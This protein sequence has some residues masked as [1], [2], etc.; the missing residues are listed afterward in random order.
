MRLSDL[1]LREDSSGSAVGGTAIGTHVGTLGAWADTVK[2]NNKKRK[3]KSGHTVM[4]REAK[5]SMDDLWTRGYHEGQ[6]IG[7][8]MGLKDRSTK[9][10]PKFTGFHDPLARGRLTRANIYRK[11]Y[12]AGL[13]DG[14]YDAWTG[15]VRG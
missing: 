15:A 14:Y 6:D 8:E 3:L 5:E 7:F 10:T 4:R 1:R 13:Q 12:E 2:K 11:A 9:A